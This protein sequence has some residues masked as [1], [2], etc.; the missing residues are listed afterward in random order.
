[1]TT[2]LAALPAVL[3]PMYW[4]G[5]GGLFGTSVLLGVMVIIFIETGLLFP[6]LPG[7]TLLFSA[8]LIA[9]QP[10]S[11]VGIGWL[12]LCAALA[13]FLG[14][15]CGYL[16]GRGVGPALFNKPDSR[17]FKQSYLT[18]AHG[19]FE[20]HGAKALLVT[21]FIGVVRTY[22]PV[23]AGISTMR[24]RTF[25][26]FTALGSLAWGV[27]LTLVGYFLGNV[28]FIGRH[29]ELMILGVAALSCVPVL[30]AGVRILL[31]RRQ[32]RPAAPAPATQA[33]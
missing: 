14:S 27:G 10:D 5:D 30:V 15:Q 25:A 33:R 9:A 26:T 18:A 28:D 12:T 31:Q 29:L 11:P 21:Q 16:I 13:A 2:T 1:M 4:L 19:F 32:T 3:D 24:Y 22:T 20:K 23:V 17:V 8:G 7:D 6:F